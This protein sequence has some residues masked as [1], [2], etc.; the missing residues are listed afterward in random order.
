MT[1]YY[2]NPNI[3][4]GEEYEKRKAEQIRFLELYNEKEGHEN[5]ILFIEGPYD[6]DSFYESIKGFE[7]EPEGGKR[8][9]KCFELRLA[10]T[11][12]AGA[13][14]GF[15]CFGTTLSVSPHKNYALISRIGKGLEASE[16]IA[17]LDMDFKKK[18]GYQRSVQIS[19]EYQLYRQNY[20]GCEF[21]K[22]QR[23]D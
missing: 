20:C 10:A 19:K 12:K 14:M 1:V 15:D 21:S 13:G 6:R 7:E 18:A 17:F 16:N 8:C 9:E 23:G 4:A 5:P 3:T 2:C 22:N 11:A